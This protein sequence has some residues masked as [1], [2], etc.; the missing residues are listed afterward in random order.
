MFLHVLLF[1]ALRLPP[2]LRHSANQTETAH[3]GSVASLISKSRRLAVSSELALFLTSASQHSLQIVFSKFQ[4]FLGTSIK[5][6]GYREPDLNG[7]SLGRV[8]LQQPLESS[9]TIKLCSFSNLDIEYNG[10][11]IVTTIP[12]RLYTCQFESCRTTLNGGAIWADL[13]DSDGRLLVNDCDLTFC[14]ANSGGAV[15]CLNGRLDIFRT[16]FINCRATQM[17]GGFYYDSGPNR[18]LVNVLSCMFFNCTTIS[19]NSPMFWASLSGDTPELHLDFTRC[20]QPLDPPYTNENLTGFTGEGHWILFPLNCF[21]LYRTRFATLLENVHGTPTRTFTA[22]PTQSMTSPP[23]SETVSDSPTPTESGSPEITVTVTQIE[24]EA[25][26]KTETPSVTKTISPEQSMSVSE[27]ESPSPS[28]SQSMSPAASTT[29]PK[30]DTPTETLSHSPTATISMT[31]S[32]TVSVSQ[33]PMATPTHSATPVPPWEWPEL[34]LGLLI[35][36][37]II[38]LTGLIANLILCMLCCRLDEILV[39]QYV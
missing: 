11:A 24:T 1:V 2:E 22:I 5:L 31:P 29:K 27:S 34:G 37:G 8:N 28:P 35:L 14:G 12:L 4:N 25:A 10:S 30:T 23:A 16:G 32:P 19:T 26:T 38:V 18:D 39:K 36:L 9:Y 17:G 21:N 3:L 15:Y 6:G 20:S 7:L 13:I 33:T